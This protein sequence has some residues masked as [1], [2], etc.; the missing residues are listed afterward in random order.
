MLDAI[1]I[2]TRQTK[3]V[4]AI[5]PKPPFLPNFQVAVS[6]KETDIRIKNE[7]LETSSKVPSVF[8]VETGE[9]LSLRE[10]GYI[11]MDFTFTKSQVSIA[12]GW[13]FISHD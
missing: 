5:K 2:D 9:G 1:Y 12:N 6:K 3:S 10:I 13:C 7:P 4:A 8:L 11:I